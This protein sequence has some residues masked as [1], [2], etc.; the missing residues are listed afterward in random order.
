MNIRFGRRFW[1]S[2]LVL[3]AI[4]C[5]NLY[6]LYGDGFSKKY[7]IVPETEHLL[8]SFFLAMWLSCFSRST[9]FIL[10][11]IIIVTGLWEG[12]EY[13]IAFAPSAATT[14]QDVLKITN[15]DVEVWD[16]V[17]DVFLNFI[18]ALIF[19]FTDKKGWWNFWSPTK[20]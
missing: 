16:T 6:G 12:L 5:I 20:F 2:S 11:G 14:V 18:G 8:A 10:F 4:F 3:F 15:V 13:Y 7:Y 9:R 1:I 19:I 17:L